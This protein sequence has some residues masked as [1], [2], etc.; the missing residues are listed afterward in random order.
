MLINNLDRKIKNARIGLALG[1]GGAR[2]LTHLEIL[3]VFDKL[4]LRPKIISGTSIGAIMGALYGCGYSG[5]DIEKEFRDIDLMD[6][7]SL[8]DLTF[9]KRK[10]LIKGKK[11]EK[12]LK[13]KT[14]NIYFKDLNLPLKIVATDFWS[15]TQR[16]F[17]SGPV[18]KAIRASISIPGVFETVSIDGEE[19]MDGGSVNPVPYDLIYD[20]CD[21]GI[22]VDVL[23]ERHSDEEK[24]GKPNIFNSIIGNYQIVQEALM[25]NKLK[26]NP[27]DI[28]IKPALVD[29]GILE[30]YKIDKVLKEAQKD[31]DKLE[32]ILTDNL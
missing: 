28:Y 25:E 18:Y 4:D 13:E 30:F 17:T 9:F 8:I 19:L 2:G 22:A 10:G 32:K 12:Y 3:K 20:E 5:E 6:A 29:V 24:G 7:G 27:P 21:I 26:V 15:G 1:G 14:G 16:V 31:T 23:G 11:I